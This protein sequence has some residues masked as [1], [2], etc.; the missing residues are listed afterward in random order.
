MSVQLYKP[1]HTSIKQIFKR[2]DT[3]DLSKSDCINEIYTIKGWIAQKRIQKNL[4]FIEVYDGSS[5]INLQLVLN[6]GTEKEKIEK[7]II[8][9]A[10]ICAIGKIIV[11]EGKGQPIEMQ[12]VSCDIIGK[13]HDPVTYIPAVKGAS[14]ELMRDHQDLR[15][16]FSSIQSIFRIRSKLMELVHRFFHER[17]VH[18]LDPNIITTADCEGAGENFVLTTLFKDKEMPVLNPIILTD[19]SV[20]VENSTQILKYP[21]DADFSKD[22]FGKKAFLTVSS[23]LQLEAIC[24]GMGSVYTTNPS[25]RGEESKTKR[26]LGCFTHLEWELPFIDLKDLMDFSEDLVKY[27]FKGVVTESSDDLHKLNKFTS[28]GIID[29]LNSFLSD[30]F[31]R[32][33]YNEAILMIRKHSSK[34]KKMFPELKE[35]PKWGDDLGSFCER[36]ICSYLK[37]P[38]FVYNYPRDLKSFYMK[39]NPKP[40]SELHSVEELPS[41]ETVQGC[42]LLIPGLGELIGSSI[43]EDDYDILMNEINRRKM[44]PK[45]LSWYTELRRNGTFPHGGAGLGFD[46]LVSVCT[47]ME[48]NIR[49]VVPFPVAFKECDY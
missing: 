47:L 16:K 15:V 43:R 23:Q 26:H 7:D 20:L 32:I 25:F 44:D 11:S 38:T 27:C 48:G 35:I 5:P 6:E 8:V 31:N 19:S 17:D 2:V 4:M 29:K 30:R 3:Q 34:I 22:F 9:G 39:Q 42:D 24:S 33:S 1:K 28:K 46:R 45:P 13:I 36:F 37:A 49:D 41:R 21:F 18:H 14:L 12:I 10:S 40:E